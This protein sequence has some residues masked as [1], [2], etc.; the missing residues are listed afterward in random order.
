VE[1]RHVLRRGAQS[2][3]GGSERMRALAR[4]V[5]VGLDGARVVSNLQPSVFWACE[6]SGDAGGSHCAVCNSGWVYVLLQALRSGTAA[7]A[8]EAEPL[9]L[10]LAHQLSC[11]HVSPQKHPSTARWYKTAIASVK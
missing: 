10:R 6:R 8:H 2:A 5:D 3:Q 7:L 9:R 11:W 1:F 4:R